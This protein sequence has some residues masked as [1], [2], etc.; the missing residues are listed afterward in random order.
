MP[1]QHER[2]ILEPAH[3]ELRLTPDWIRGK[4]LIEG[5]AQPERDSVKGRAPVPGKV[6]VAVVDDGDRRAAAGVD[7]HQAPAPGLAGVEEDRSRPLRP[8]RA[9]GIPRRVRDQPDAAV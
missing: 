6:G 2:S 9:P 4:P 7:A 1:T 3:P 8:A 5:Q